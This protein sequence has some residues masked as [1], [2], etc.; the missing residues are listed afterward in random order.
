MRISEKGQV[1]IPKNL[2]ELAGLKPDSEVRIMLEGNRVVIEGVDP[3][4]EKAKE[5]RIARFLEDLRNI[6][7]TGDLSLN[8]KDVMAATRDRD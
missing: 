3:R 5:A 4:N 8:A 6:E 2:R 7:N 1:T